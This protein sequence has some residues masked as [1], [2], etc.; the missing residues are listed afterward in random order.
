MKVIDFGTAQ[1]YNPAI[2]MTQISG[3]S[4]YIAPEVLAHSYNEKCD[5][6][7]IGV[8]MYILLSG[9]PPFDGKSERD[10][11]TSVKLGQYSLNGREWTNISKEAKDLIKRMLTYKP[12][13]RIS[14][15]EALSHKW[16]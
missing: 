13:K 5:V 16:I 14:A 1:K 10:I 9:E 7:S 4:Y 8:L 11:L 12:E 2:P 3:T 6:W 15:K